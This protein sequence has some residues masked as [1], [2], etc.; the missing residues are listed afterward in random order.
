MCSGQAKV[1]VV[2]DEPSIADLLYEDLSEAGYDC[3]K[4]ATGEDALMRLSQNHCDV[5]L[6]DLNLPGISGMDVLREV[7]ASHSE[8]A[9]IVITAAGD[10]QTAVEAMKSGAV[11]YITKPFELEMVY[12]SIEA[13]FKSKV[14]WSSNSALQ[15]EL[16]EA[17][18][19]EMDWARCL[20][21]MARGVEARLDSMLNRAISETI[22]E[23]TSAIAR[24]LDIPD[25]YVEKWA[26]AR[27]RQVVEFISKMDALQKELEQ[28]PESKAMILPYLAKH[29]K[30]NYN[31]N[32]NVQMN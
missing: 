29:S 24:I 9:I 28:N 13:V 4:A 11:D 18:D 2:D 23:E 22:V 21:N 26:E 16:S 17:S 32:S 14:I 12:N 7:R 30:Y 19:K 5:M 15:E 6:L 8:T 27:R 25:D 31:N 10:A 20:D 3:I 1:L